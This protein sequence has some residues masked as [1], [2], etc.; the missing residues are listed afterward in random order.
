[1]FQISTKK[2][3]RVNQDVTDNMIHP[4]IECDSREVYTYLYEV[5]E[6]DAR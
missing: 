6:N 2:W 1:M 5:I 4:D 3:L